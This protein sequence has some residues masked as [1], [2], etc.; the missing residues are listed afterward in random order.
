MAG[1]N[2][3]GTREP[4]SPLPGEYER[5]KRRRLLTVTS[6]KHELADV[7]KELRDGIGDPKRQNARVF[8]LSK[9]ADIIQASDFE[10]RL[11]RI[12]RRVTSGPEEEVTRQ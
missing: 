3:N 1:K 5:G 11:R 2:G 7:C 9:L 6:I 12:E 10:D 4:C 8:A